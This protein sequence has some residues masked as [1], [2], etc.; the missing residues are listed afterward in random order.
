[1]FRVEGAR[2]RCCEKMI[3]ITAPPPLHYLASHNTEDD[4]KL[5]HEQEAKWV[6]PLKQR[7]T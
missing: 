3:V 5:H 4:P 6:E 7:G 2:G 1:M